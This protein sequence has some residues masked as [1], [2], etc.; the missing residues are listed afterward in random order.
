MDF[1]GILTIDSYVASELFKINDVLR[2]LGINMVFTGIRP[3]LATKSITAGIDFSSIKTYSSV[4]KA[5]E[6]IK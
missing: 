6:V 2:L 3:D 4:L 5:I 1:Y